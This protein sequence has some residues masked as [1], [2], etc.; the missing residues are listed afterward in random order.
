MKNNR[1]LVII[2]FT[3]L[4]VLFNFIVFFLPLDKTTTFW[5][6]YVFTSIALIQVVVVSY[7]VLAKKDPLKDKFLNFSL[8][9]ISYRYFITQF[10]LGLVLFTLVLLKLDQDYFY[11]SIIGMILSV[12]FLGF[13]ITK[14]SFSKLGINEVERLDKEVANKVDFIKQTLMT[15]EP[16]AFRTKDSTLK[17]AMSKLIETIRYSDP[18]SN[19]ASKLLEDKIVSSIEHL[20]LNFEEK[21]ND[22][23]M[24]EIEKI[25][26]LFQQRNA[27]IK[28]KK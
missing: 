14:L 7:L 10:V 28:Y 12:G 13:T 16:L 15:V 24:I 19:E 23:V 5:I 2:G 21:S 6:A 18:M 11:I 27:L 26:E 4:F 20:N 22:D 3:S 25:I 9:Q 17:K 1:T 8:I